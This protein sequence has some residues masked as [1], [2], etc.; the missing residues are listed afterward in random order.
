LND[1]LGAFGIYLGNRI[2]DGEF[3]I[4]ENEASFDSGTTIVG[5]PQ[6]GVLITS[7][8]IDQTKQVLKSKTE[9]Q[10]A[11]NILGFF[12]PLQNGLKQ[13]ATVNRRKKRKATKK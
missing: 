7:D 8:L 2:Y 5:F 1:L 4:S 11:V 10:H 9:K 12:I 3:S 6:R 13:T